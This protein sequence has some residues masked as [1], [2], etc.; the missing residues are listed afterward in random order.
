MP[1]FRQL[2]LLIQRSLGTILVAV[3]SGSGLTTTASA[4]DSGS[5]PYP[6][7]AA[8]HLPSGRKPLVTA[9]RGPS[10]LISTGM[11]GTAEARLLRRQRAEKHRPVV[12]SGG[13]RPWAPE[14]VTASPANEASI[15][16]LPDGTLRI[17]WIVQGKYCASMRSRDHGKTW[18][19]PVIEFSVPEHAYVTTQALVDRDGEIHVCFLVG[20]GVGNR[21]PAV[22]LF[23]DIWHTKTVDDR[24][25]WLPARRIYAGYVGALRCML[26]LKDGRILLPFGKWLPPAERKPATGSNEVRILYSDDGGTTWHEAP[27]ALTAPVRPHGGQIGAVEPTALQLKDG[28][29]WMLIRTDTGRLYEAFSRDGVVWTPAKPSRFTSS[30]SPATLL[31]LPDQRIVLIWNNCQELLPP[32]GRRYAAYSGRDVLHAAISDDEG[33]TWRGFREIFRDP[34][35]NQTPPRHGDRGTAYPHATAT[36]NGFVVVVTGQGEGRRAVVRFHPDWLCETSQFEDFSHGLERW[37]VFHAVGPLEHVWRDRIQGPKLIPHP[38]RKGRRVL[39]VRRAAGREGD[40][41]VWNFPMG[42]RGELSIRIMPRRGFQRASIAL[43]DRF[44]DPADPQG[45]RQAV[46]LLHFAAGPTPKRDDLRLEPGQW[47]TLT[48]NWDLETK[49]CDVKVDDRHVKTLNV[50]QPTVNGISYL[51]LRSTAERPDPAGFLVESI[52]VTVDPAPVPGSR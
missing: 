39:L 44:F 49:G 16:R 7:I 9:L 13:M 17:F 1:R 8:W 21:R 12:G 52:A 33:R 24:S 4:H 50:N 22:D 35:R 36:T 20:R 10:P 5:N 40:G 31:R 27:A 3:L 47:H 15:V 34:K 43:A 42:Y 30:E 19:R 26:Q 28:T 45:S 18:S 29:I 2:R 38:T 25:K 11:A 48:L 23:Y 32:P 51:R 37:S 14:V 6:A 46:F 41:A